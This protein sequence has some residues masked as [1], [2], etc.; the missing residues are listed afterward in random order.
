MLDH[1]GLSSL[2]VVLEPSWNCHS[3]GDT[4]LRLVNILLRVLEKQKE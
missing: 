4:R 2:Y 3:D 1:I